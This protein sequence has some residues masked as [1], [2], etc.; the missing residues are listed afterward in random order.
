MPI[1]YNRK[2]RCY[3]V[4]ELPSIKATET[5]GIKGCCEKFIVLANG[6]EDWQN[7]VTSAW[8][9][10]QL[11]TDNCTIVLLNDID[12]NTIYQPTLKIC[13]NDTNAVYATINWKEV[14]QQ[15]G[16]GCYKIQVNYTI[17]GNT[18]TF[19]WGEYEVNQYSP[20][21]AKNTIR[22]KSIFNQYNNIEKINF[23]DC[24]VVDTIRF[25]GFFGKRQT[26][27]IIDN[28]IYQN[29]SIGN[30]Q[31]E[32][33]NSYILKTDPLTINYTNKILD[34]HLLSEAE[35][36]LS[37]HNPLNHTSEY[38]NIPLSIAESAEVDYFDYS[39]YAN[40]TCKFNDKSR[41]KYTNALI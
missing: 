32:N 34:L 19:I 31:R 4:I 9:K 30:V 24:K 13:V 12:V 6:I 41:T 35:I 26:N 3:K 20:D 21:N 38:K 25:Y 36:H 5:Y 1:S 17:A 39:I 10:K 22:I 11:D 27:V 15:D 18:G 16:I 28:L 8:F 14:I 33:L 7:D 29:R 23:L 37:D 40:I 2:K